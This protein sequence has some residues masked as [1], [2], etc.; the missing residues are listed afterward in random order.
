MASKKVFGRTVA[1]VRMAGVAEKKPV[2]R[3]DHMRR[4]IE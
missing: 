4:N 2:K 1:I 3:A